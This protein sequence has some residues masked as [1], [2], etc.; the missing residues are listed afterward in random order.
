MTAPH[1]RPL[2]RPPFTPSR[3]R[4]APSRPGILV[5]LLLLLTACSGDEAPASPSEQGGSPSASRGE[6]G[7]GGSERG[8]SKEGGSERSGSERGGSERGGAQRGGSG[9]SR[10]GGV[11]TG[12]PGGF[13]GAG[14]AGD[15]RGVP[16]EVA[17]VVRQPIASYLETH[18]TLE[19]E[20][21]VDLVA[22]TAGPIIE[23][24]AE[25]GMTVRAGQL[26]AR[27]DDREIKSQLE[28][29]KVRLEETRL[30]FE[31]AKQLR[32]SELVSQETFDQALANYQSAQGDF[33]RLR[34]Q[35]QY[36]EITAPFNGLIVE[37][38]VKFAQHLT[39][40]AQLFR[41]SDFDPLL[42]PIQVPERELPRLR[43]GQPA[44]LEVEAWDG[45]TFDAK[46]LRLSPVIDAAT[47]TIRVTLEVGG[48]GKLRPGMFA[49]VYLEMA[50]KP[51]ALVV[52]KSALA[53]D[54]LGDTV[55]VVDGDVAVRRAL[56]LGFQNDNLLEVRSGLTEGEQVIVVGQDGLSEGTP[57]E[58]LRTV[59]M[60]GEQLTEDNTPTEKATASTPQ[61]PSSADD[62]PAATPVAANGAGGRERGGRRGPEGMRNID[63]DDPEQVE[64]V[65]GL[66]R[67][68]GLSD[69][70][71]EQRLKQIR[72][73][74]GGG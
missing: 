10:P 20:N 35:M 65:K 50:R 55:F 59:D 57:I 14:A 70:E 22:R 9:G 41:I 33:E 73:R 23:L 17:T 64:R 26:L 6:S 7:R 62:A 24:V 72:A 12:S 15:N 66:M 27:I 4:G 44:R 29:S 43:V 61:R 46:V 48:R 47:G 16:V 69:E 71:I 40:G 31:R 56:E 32:N 8:G 42:C 38:Y 13:P 2:S 18:G 49:S 67:Q 36:T 28:V 52:L 21:E 53:L 11:P 30:A 37:R 19:A 51:D 60:T 74:R 45:E 58:I 68:R 54:S 63:F 5:A 34:I 39:S 1:S 25:E 3:E